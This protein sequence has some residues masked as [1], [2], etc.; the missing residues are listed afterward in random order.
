[1]EADPTQIQQVLVNLALNARDAMVEGGQLLIS[2]S[3]VALSPKDVER[4]RPMPPGSYVALVVNDTGIGMSRETRERIFE[5]FF[6]T[7]E[8]GRGTG[9]GLA[10]AYGIVKQSGGFIWVESE[11]RQG[12]T[13]R[14]FLPRVAKGVEVEERVASGGA[15]TRGSETVLLVEDEEAVRAVMRL[16]LIQCGYRILEAA[17]AGAAFELCRLHSGPLHLVITDV[18]IPQLSGPRLFERIAEVHPEARVLYVSGYPDETT[19]RR[20]LLSPGRN[21]LEK[22]F[23]PE[24]LQRKVRE[25]LETNVAE[26]TNR[27]VT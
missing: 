20:G 12:A 2:T 26:S 19:T 9:M 3:N 13:F 27:A 18:V 14:V 11:P 6:T 23:T 17:S 24:A 5:P 1:V 25:L 7:K 15:A 8:K 22:P 21:F 10:T 4:Y 16:S